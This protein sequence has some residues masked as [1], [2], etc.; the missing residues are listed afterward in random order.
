MS[1]MNGQPIDEHDQHAHRHGGQ[2]PRMEQYFRAMIRSGASDLHLKAGVPPHVRLNS[3]LIPTRAEVLP[4]D[5]IHDMAM[6]LLTPKQKTF[7][8]EQG[9]IDLAHEIEGSDRFRINIYR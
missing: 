6:E 2:V 4:G 5:E 7:F 1:P 8:S 3:L 9:S